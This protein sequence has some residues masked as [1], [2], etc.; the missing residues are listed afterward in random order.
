MNNLTKL[1]DYSDGATVLTNKTFE[2]GVR[3]KK[4]QRLKIRLNIYIVL[5]EKFVSL[6]ILMN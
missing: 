6:V 5:T 4:Y 2:I 3:D 1:S